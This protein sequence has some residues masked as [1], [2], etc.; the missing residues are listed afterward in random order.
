MAG[1][2]WGSL[3]FLYGPVVAMFGLG[4]LI[5]FLRW[6]WTRGKSVVGASS[7]PGD[8]DNY[9]Q[10]EVVASC[11]NLIEAEVLKLALKD[12]GIQATVA[13]QPDRKLWFGLKTMRLQKVFCKS[14]N[15]FSQFFLRLHRD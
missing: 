3:S 5:L 4:I 11:A 1:Q 10:L 14:E 9:G 8:P 13:N 7:R 12:A 15:L 2:S 6:G